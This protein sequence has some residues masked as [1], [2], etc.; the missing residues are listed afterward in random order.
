MGEWDPQE[1]RRIGAAT[2]LHIAS[3][4]GDGS[5]RPSIPIWHASLGDALYVRSAHGP[6]NGW[7]RRAVASGS[8]RVSAGGVEKDVTFEIADA[9]IR[10]ALD[11][12]LHGKYD[13]YGPGPIGAIT[14]ADVLQTTLRLM[15]RD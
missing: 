10:T 2:E 8:G 1:L 6:E 14:G 5:L 3:Y 9:D 4:R 12:A 15:P 13:G 7:F 11:A